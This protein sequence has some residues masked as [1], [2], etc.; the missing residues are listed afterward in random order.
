MK[1]IRKICGLI[2]AVVFVA[3]LIIGL[4]VI[5]SVKNVNVT[6]ESYTYN[7][8]SMTDEQREEVAQE[9]G[10]VKE[11]LLGKYRGTIMGF[12]K[13]EEAADCLDG[14]RY[15]FVGMEK[16]YP[17]TLEITI[18]ERREVF[19]VALGEGLYDTYDVSGKKLRS[20]VMAEEA[21]NNLDGEPNVYVVKTPSAVPTDGDML[22]VASVAAAF[23]EAFGGLRPV[24][25]SIA[26]NTVYDI[27][28]PRTDMQFTLRCGIAVYI[29]DYQVLTGA[30]IGKAFTAFSALGGV[31]KMSG[32]IHVLEKDG[33]LIA[34]RI[35]DLPE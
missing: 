23:S 14:S 4:G 7:A 11:K 2:I 5:F 31:E 20:G 29:E 22:E 30:K 10:G 32:R 21:V 9:L 1:Y 15:V 35:P 34:E 28:V 16:H 17:C 12:V 18:K 26:V 13:E 24:V 25:E 27:N 33:Q 19:A 8:E 6:L 3:A